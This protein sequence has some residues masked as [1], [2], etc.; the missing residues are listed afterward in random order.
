MDFRRLH[1]FS[2]VAALMSFNRAAELLHCAQS[3]VSAQIKALEEE[4]GVA[5]FN[6]FGKRIA[7]TPA[8]ETYLTYARKLLQLQEEARAKT[9]RDPAPTTLLSLR[10]PQ[11]LAACYLPE[12]L[13]RFFARWPLVSLDVGV[14]AFAELERELKAGITDAAFLLADGVDSPRLKARCLAVKELC[15]VAGPNSPLAALPPLGWEEL[16]QARLFVPKHDCSYKM[17]L[18]REFARRKLSPRGL[19]SCNGLDMLYACLERGLGL[20][21]VPEFSVADRLRRQALVRLPWKEP[22]LESALLAIVHKEARLCEELSDLLN[23]CA[24]IMG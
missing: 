21:L 17:L 16:A 20:A 12:I 11:S 22:S 24:E 10:M 23:I 2:T 14:C 3:T 9:L 5:L 6:R 8:G 13:E 7:L 18:E 19:T 1:A 15:F 4:L